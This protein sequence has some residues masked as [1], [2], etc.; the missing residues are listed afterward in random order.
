[1][2]KKLSQNTLKSKENSSKLDVYD[3]KLLYYYSKNCRLPLNKL[4]KLVG[5]SKDSVK[6]RIERFK[7]EGI[8]RGNTLVID[9]IL[10]GHEF[11]QVYLKFQN[12]TLEKEQDIVNHLSNFE[13]N[14][15]VMKTSGLWDMYILLD[16]G[17]AMQFGDFLQHIR[18]YC[19]DYLKDFLFLIE[20]KEYLFTNIPKIIFKDLK[21]GTFVY[22]KED[23]SF[24]KRLQHIGTEFEHAEPIRANDKELQL[25]KEMDNNIQIELKDLASKLN[26]SLFQTKSMI[27]SLIE[28]KALNAFWPT[29]NLSRLGLE[30]YI[31][32]MQTNNISNE[33]DQKLSQYFKNHPNLMR[34]VRT[35]GNYDIILFVT[36]YNQAELY[37]IMKDMRSKFPNLLKNY[38]SFVVEEDLHFKAGTTFYA[39]EKGLVL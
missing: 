19:G 12:L 30:Y 10:L 11:F 29:F 22:E 5:R 4:A 31:V 39:V 2:T 37:G 33:I 1:M 23:S 38:E 25:F 16:A 14:N 8:V 9:P 18:N 28:K 24:Q 17:H 6:Y 27:K 35:I 21:I 20:S 15:V 34:A 7:R 13:A 32:F 3:R 26:L 36:V